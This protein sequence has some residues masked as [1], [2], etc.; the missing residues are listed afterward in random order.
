MATFGEL[1]V[2][3]LRTEV[4]APAELMPEHWLP[5]SNLDLIIPSTD[6]GVFFCYNKPTSARFMTFT[7]VISTLKSALARALVHYFPF[8]GQLVH[9]SAGE[10]ELLCNNGGVDFIEAH[11]NLT[12]RDLD[13]HKPDQTVRGKLVPHR[14]RGVLSVQVRKRLAHR[15]DIKNE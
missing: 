8:A 5:A 6:V 13:L 7:S 10:P 12:L 15:S 2:T 4:V 3:L 9:N 11:A 14:E 1:E